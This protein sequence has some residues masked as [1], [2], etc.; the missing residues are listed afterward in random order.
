MDELVVAGGCFWGMEELFRNQQGVVD[1]EVGY[2]GG[3]NKHP[4]YNNRPG[5]A[6][7]IKIIYDPKQTSI[8]KLLDYFFQIHDPTTINRQ[9]NDIGVSYRSTFF[10]KNKQQKIRAEQAIKR[11][12]Q[13]WDKPIVTT[14]EVLKTF[15]P[16]EQYHQ[17]YLQENPNGYT[18][19][20]E[21]P[22]NS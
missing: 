22:R 20:F 9:G 10:Y 21:R 5:H 18:C 7:A 3:K 6:E 16:A 12:Q 14:L 1:T 17:D 11:N 15:W 8:D 2:S 4:T 19:H 13:Y